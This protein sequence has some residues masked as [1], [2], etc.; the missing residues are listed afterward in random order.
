M[1]NTVPVLQS[2]DPVLTVTS[3]S[4]SRPPVF[5]F[6]GYLAFGSGS[7]SGPAAPQ[8]PGPAAPHAPGPAAPQAPV[9][10]EMETDIPTTVDQ[11][12]LDIKEEDEVKK[13]NRVAP[14]I[15]SSP[16]NVIPLVFFIVH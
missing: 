2:R 16:L 7:S 11:E 13:N 12:V 15:F 6:P 8:A 9:E 4:S 1:D 10:M 14:L 5:S 3:S